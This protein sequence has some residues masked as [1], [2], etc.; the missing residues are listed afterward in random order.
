MKYIFFVFILLALVL[1]ACSP[2]VTPTAIPAA[3]SAAATS[4][5]N[6]TPAPTQK[7]PP[8]PT[9]V[10]SATLAAPAPTLTPASSG[11]PGVNATQTA[12]DC[13]AFPGF[14]GCGASLPL[15]GKLATFDV[16]SQ[17]ITVLDF[18]TKLAWKVN[19]PPQTQRLEWLDGGNFLVTYNNQ[20][21]P[22]LA[23]TNPVTSKTVD[24]PQRNPQGLPVFKAAD[25]ST[26]WLEMKDTQFLFHV[27]L[28]QSGQEQVW[29]AGPP[30]DTIHDLLGWVPGAPLLLAG[31]HF[32]GNSMWVDGDRL[33]TLDPASGT[34]Q[35][36]TANLRLGASFDWHPTQTGLMVFGDSNPS[37]MM[38]GPR[39]AVLDV[40]TG[41]VIHLIADESVVSSYPSWTPDGKA[42][43]H[44]AGKGNAPVGPGDPFGLSAIYLTPYPNGDTRRLTNP[45]GGARDD[46][47]RLLPDGVHFLYLRVPQGGQPV[48]LR[49]GTLDGSQD[50]LVGSGLGSTPLGPFP[51]QWESI[52]AYTP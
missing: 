14:P 39:L 7:A 42:I 36:L 46:W 12:P 22:S 2:G 25:G 4:L 23:W 21:Q 6:S 29:P 16:A 11:A 52:I 43:L 27:R 10:P 24:L 49:L 19:A 28:G 34:I 30:S 45:S 9:V 13:A 40:I 37:Q 38:G 20:D 5:P 48:E 3:P 15:S 35:E 33:Y 32:S 50:A 8:S 41:K 31:Y 18:T 26:A 1:G 51:P 44:A 47:P 17:T